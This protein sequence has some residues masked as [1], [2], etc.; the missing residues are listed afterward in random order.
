MEKSI[1][2]SKTFWVSIALLLITILNEITQTF[3][4]GSGTIATIFTIATIVLRAITKEA[5]N[6][7]FWE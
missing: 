1:I 5:V 7:K 6:W 3:P 4:L 2:K